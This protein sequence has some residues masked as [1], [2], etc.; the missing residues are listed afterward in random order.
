MRTAAFLLLSL[1]LTSTV[2]GADPAEL[3][4]GVL[5]AHHASQLVFSQD[6]PPEG[7][8][9]AYDPYA[10]GSLGEVSP[11]IYGQDLPVVWYV[12]AAWGSE[13]KTWCGLDFGFGDFDPLGFDFVE[14]GPCFPVDGL[15]LPS[16]GW[17]GPN[18]GTAIVTTGQPWSGNWLPV[19]YF[20]GYAGYTYGVQTSIALAE[21][22]V[23][24]DVT[25]SNCQSPPV[26]FMYEPGQ[27]GAL[28][29]NQPGMVPGFPPPL[30]AACCFPTGDCELLT[31]DDCLAGQGEW[32]WWIE[33]CNPNPCPGD[34]HVCCFD[35]GGC[36]LFDDEETCTA[37]GGTWHPEWS[38]C[39]PNPC[40]QP[41][42]CCVEEDCLIVYSAQACDDLGGIHHPEWSDCTP[43]PC[44]SVCCFEDGSCQLVTQAVCLSTGGMWRPE[45]GQSCDP[46]PCPQPTVCCVLGACILVF[47]PEECAGMGGVYHP[48]WSTCDP[49]PCPEPTPV[50][51]FDD[52]SCLLLTYQEC[53]AAGGESYPLESCDPNPCPQP[54]VC[55]AY[56]TC[57]VVYSPDECSQLP[58]GVYHPEWTSCDPNPCPQE[59]YVC[60]FDDGAC[61]VLLEDACDQ[62]HGTWRPGLGQSCDPNP[63][64][65]PKVCCIY[66]ECTLTISQSECLTHP[67]G[68]FYPQWTSCDPNPCPQ[69]AYV[70]CLPYGGCELLTEPQCVDAGGEWHPQWGQSCTPNP[71]EQ[72]PY[73]CCLPGD[74]CELLTHEQCLQAGGEWLPELG[75]SCDPNPCG[76]PPGPHN[77]EA[78]ALFA[79]YVPELGYTIDPPAGGWCQAYDS[80][81]ISSV[82]ELATRI[83]VADRLPA[84]WYVLAAWESEEKIWC[85]TQFGFGDFD[86]NLFGFE[87]AF[88]CFPD[89]GLEI[90]MSGWPGPN[91]GT[92]FV[93]T[94]DPWE[95][96]WVQVYYFG[97]YAYGYGGPGHIPLDVDPTSDFIGFSN[98]MVPPQQYEVDPVRRGVLGINTDGYPA[99]G[100]GYDKV[101][102][103]PTGE[104]QITTPFECNL[105]N[106]IWHPEWASCDPNPCPLEPYVC[107]FEDGSCEVLLE[108]DCDSAGGTWL[109]ELGRS[110]DP[111]PCPQPSVCCIYGECRLL[112]SVGE[113]FALGGVWH[114]GWG[115]CE[116]NPCPQDPYV[117]CLSDGSCL[118]LPE[119][120]CLAAGGEW[121]PELGQSCE[122]NPCPNAAAVCCFGY[123]YEECGIMTQPECEA[124]NGFWHPEWATCDPNPCDMYVRSQKTTWGRIKLIYR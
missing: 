21:D 88:A 114:P 56:N 118:L 24:G 10:I 106:G 80:Y 123:S 25:V 58:G 34:P 95:G 121:M 111:N 41:T 119:P 39:D 22:P 98:C 67:G 76:G 86:P 14:Q 107:C 2:V 82:Q 89:E 12:V 97:G 72:E 73:V 108:E 43:N 90:P 77:L 113:C 44:P 66:N 59:A 112:F 84:S 28:G 17:P 103:L 37:V 122:P 116:P 42:V 35:D 68:V 6:P 92:A 100:P 1:V 27:L 70:C 48:E 91:L 36:T 101:C 9:A 85:G 16:G 47:S 75:Q 93:V 18:E 53:L 13:E 45:L 61:Q 79:H 110:C 46:N 117:C 81:A 83:D 51:C 60:C 62:A 29:I 19:Y 3:S 30:E 20:G 54:A 124:L 74:V 55:C 109:P 65:Q 64:P 11:E 26:V 31:E 49:N 52:G 105:L 115:S 5:I 102:C 99:T 32:L 69:E 87:E 120:D 57:Y 33:S 63:C 15:E 4:G 7:W 23:T 50:C 96:N 78:G 40:P 38:S 94:T 104:C 71:C 8:C